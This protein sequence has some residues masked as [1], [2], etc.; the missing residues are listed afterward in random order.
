MA[1]LWEMTHDLRHPMHVRHHAVLSEGVFV[2]MHAYVFVR[3]CVYMYVYVYVH[4]H[5]CI[6]KC[7]FV[8]VYI[9]SLF[10][11]ACSLLAYIHFV[12]FNPMKVRCIMSMYKYVM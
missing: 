5:M 3:R 12:R 4:L 6:C 9:R 1:I 8:Y 7:V 11:H 10:L 2:H